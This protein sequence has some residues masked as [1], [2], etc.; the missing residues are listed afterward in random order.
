[1]RTPPNIRRS[2]RFNL[3][4]AVLGLT[5]LCAVLFSTISLLEVMA[6]DSSVS[7]S[8]SVNYFRG[9]VPVDATEM[10]L[11]GGVSDTTLTDAEGNYQFTGLEAGLDYLITPSKENDGAP[12]SAFDASLLLRLLCNILSFSSHDSIAADVTEDGTVSAF[13]ASVIL[14]YVVTEGQLIPEH[15][16]GRWFLIPEDIAYSSLS[17]DQTDQD[18]VGLIIGD[19]SGNWRQPA[20]PRDTV[21]VS[22]PEKSVLPGESFRVYIDI[23]EVEGQDIFST[24]CAITYDESILTITMIGGEGTI[25]DFGALTYSIDEGKASVAYAGHES[26]EEGGALACIEF[27]VSPDARTGQTSPLHF[28]YFMFNEGDPWA[29]TVDGIITIISAP[30]IAVSDTS[31]DFGQA[32]IGGSKEWGLKISNVGIED[33]IVFDILSDHDAF[34]VDMTSFALSP[35]SSEDVTVTFAPSDESDFSGHLTIISNDLDETEVNVS[36]RG[37]G[38]ISNPDIDISP[39]AHNFGHVAVHG[40]ASGKQTIS[41]V[42]TEMLSVTDII[43]DSPD[44]T[45]DKTTFD[46]KPDTSEKVT[47]TCSPGTEGP[48]SGT[49]TIYSDDP[50]E[51]V[52]VVD[53]QA[54]G[55]APEA[56][57]RVSDG[58]GGPGTSG[59]KVSI[60]LENR[61]EVAAM[62]LTLSFDSDV[63]RATDVSSTPRTAHIQIFEANLNYRPGQAKLLFTGLSESVTS[64]TGP[65][66]DFFFDVDADA[67]PDIYPLTL[68]GI[69]MA[70]TRGNP[71]LTGVEGGNF[72]V[73]SGYTISGTVAYGETAIPVDSVQVIL[74]GG[75]T[76]TAYTDADGSYRFVGLQAGLDYTVT[77]YRENDDTPV[78]AYDASL[79][80]RSLCGTY[81]LS[82]FDSV[83]ADITRD[84][85]VSAFDAATILK[86]EANDSEIIP[87]H[88]IGVWSFIPENIV[89]NSLS[90][91]QTDQDYV[92]LTC[93]DVSGNWRQTTI[94]E[95]TVAVWFPECNAAPGESIR[96]Y[97]NMSDLG[98]LEVFSAQCAITYDQNTLTITNIGSEGEIYGDIGVIEYYTVNDG[99]IYI[100]WA[101][102]EPPE[103]GGRFVSVDFCVSPE[104]QVGLTCPLH[105]EYFM[106]NEGDPLALVDDGVVTIS[107]M[108]GIEEGDRSHSTPK[109][110]ALFQNRPNPFNPETR[111]EYGLPETDHVRLDVFNVLGQHIL[112]LVDEAKKTGFHTTLWD[113]RDTSGHVVPNGIYFYRLSIHGVQWTETRKMV[114]MK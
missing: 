54:T 100:A 41:N 24:Q 68:T 93:G 17:A 85:T 75:D 97:I 86:Y 11:T 31:H 49:L 4:T 53:M 99:N 15:S 52:V 79:I 57:L 103:E 74:S 29:E 3:N 83:T 77:P 8:G 108:T 12:V 22:L 63:L 9:D 14:K 38:M 34:T 10:V 67:P 72:F 55:V 30:D 81:T 60:D 105:F 64:G 62:E 46:I 78:A 35:D 92:G 45:V 96:V 107:V 102:I 13:D 84:G 82:H 5:L 98:G 42:G 112:T 7:I 43:S 104:A 25:S 69:I 1:M 19:V 2:F 76:D 110:F 32:A 37:R 113:G 101:G 106:F 89:Y 28:E 80:L 39:R 88:F 109:E 71:I 27:Q 18:Y 58:F 87:S 47:V 6:K 36:L 114:F 94:P 21:T 59:N 50:D 61:M 90:A 51:P 33:L 91:D 44:F 26:P 111:I 23:G 73:Q 20:I 56:M 40:A 48:T 66:A 95:D 70:D 65:V 16:I